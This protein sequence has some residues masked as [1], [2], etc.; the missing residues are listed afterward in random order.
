MRTDPGVI[1]TLTDPRT[2]RCHYVSSS[3]IA[4]GRLEHHLSHARSGH[5]APKYAWMRELLSLG[6]APALEVV[7]V[8]VPHPERSGRERQWIEAFVE[9][10]HPLPNERLMPLGRPPPS[11]QRPAASQLPLVAR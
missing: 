9:A 11:H 1:Y 10:G 3:F 8:G 4:A 2:G 6:L 5:T 7:D